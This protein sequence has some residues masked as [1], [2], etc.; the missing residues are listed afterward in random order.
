LSGRDG[1]KKARSASVE[2]SL[3]TPKSND[4]IGFQPVV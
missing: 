1:P 3:G 4:R 2:T